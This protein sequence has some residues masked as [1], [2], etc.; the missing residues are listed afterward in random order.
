MLRRTAT[1]GERKGL[2]LWRCID[3]TCPGIINIDPDDAAQPPVAG[4]SAQARF[5]RER[6]AQAERMHNGAP[7]IAALGVLVAFAVW[8]GSSTSSIG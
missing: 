7:V 4:E 2:D 5:E 3:G 8:F 1:R 6:S